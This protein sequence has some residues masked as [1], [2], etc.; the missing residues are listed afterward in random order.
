MAVVFHFEPRNPNKVW[1]RGK[2]APLKCPDCRSDA[3]TLIRYD[4][5]DQKIASQLGH[6]RVRPGEIIADCDE[7]GAVWTAVEDARPFGHTA[8]TIQ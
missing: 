5:G 2:G 7:C 6:G 3:L 1:N 4:A 8:K